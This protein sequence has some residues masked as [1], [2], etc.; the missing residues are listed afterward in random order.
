MPKIKDTVHCEACG[1][2]GKMPGGKKCEECSGTGRMKDAAATS[3]VDMLDAFVIDGVH[4]TADGYLA[5]F[6]RVARAGVQ[7][8]KGHELGRPDLGDVRVYRPEAEVFHADA[9]KSFAHRPVTLRHPP[10][11]VNAKNWKQYAGGL[12]GDQIVRDG[13]FVRVPMTM[14]DQAMIDAYEKGGVKE[15]SMGYSADLVWQDGETEDGEKYDAVQT[16]IR[17]NHLAVVPV[18]RGGKQLSIGDGKKG[19]KK[20]T[21]KTIMIDGVPVEVDDVSAAVVQRQI[22]KDAEQIKSLSDNLARATAAADEFKKKTE[23]ELAAEKKKVE[24]KDGEIVVLKKQVAD[25]AVTPV[26]LDALVKVRSEVIDKAKSLLDDKYVFDG[27][28][29][30]DIRKDAVTAKLGDAAKTM[31]D[32]AIEGAFNALTH[33]VKGDGAT[34]VADALRGHRPG[35]ATAS[36]MKLRDEAFA[37]HEKRLGDAWKSPSQAKAN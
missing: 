24:A 5:A 36:A 33:D 3:H 32:A 15:L 28:K 17:A 21:T 6:A 26:M 2:K 34:Q 1:S 25:A 8:Y 11:P 22:A 4:R 23:E 13:E 27:K 35:G 18:A 10:E 12:T 29:I 7:T 31:S 16:A 30:E 9:L 37:E 19:D 14:M 20:M